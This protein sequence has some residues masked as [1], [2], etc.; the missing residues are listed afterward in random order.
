MYEPG[1]TPWVYWCRVG[2]VWSAP[3]SGGGTAEIL[4]SAS[5]GTISVI[6]QDADRIY[7][8]EAATLSS[9]NK[10]TKK[11][12]TLVGPTGSTIYDIVVKDDAVW[13]IA[14][15]FKTATVYR[16]AK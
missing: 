3:A 11:V 14:G 4:A 5:G 10:V 13:W 16:L 8:A 12:T 2:K 7:W 15:D 9:V 6:A 1:V